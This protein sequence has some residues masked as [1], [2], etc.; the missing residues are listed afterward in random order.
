MIFIFFVSCFF[1]REN[2]VA[3][4]FLFQIKSKKI[5]SW[6]HYKHIKKES[7]K[8]IAKEAAGNFLAAAAGGDYEKARHY[9]YKSV[10]YYKDLEAQ[11]KI[12]KQIR[13]IV[14]IL[15]TIK[16]Y[17]YVEY[18]VFDA[19]KKEGVFNPY[20]KKSAHISIPVV[21]KA[22][23]HLFADENDF[24]AGNYAGGIYNVVKYLAEF[25]DLGQL[26]L[27]LFFCESSEDKTQA[28]R[29]IVLKG[30]KPVII[31]VYERTT[32]QFNIDVYENRKIIRTQHPEPT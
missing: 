23:I 8:T 10:T 11:G 27:F 16:E 30:P 31:G 24:P 21:P 6:A 13:V 28:V 3:Q 22:K 29:V 18:W 4:F 15:K 20:K 7:L 25:E 1:L 26:E 19:G 2:S 12:D 5:L 17:S 14:D 9:W 32:H